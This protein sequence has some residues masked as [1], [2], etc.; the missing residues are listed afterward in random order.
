MLIFRFE[1]LC[2]EN[3][4]NKTQQKFPLYGI[5]SVYPL[6]IAIEPGS[7]YDVGAYVRRLV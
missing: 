6:I 7:Q 5:A 1:A 2:N 4:E 3:N